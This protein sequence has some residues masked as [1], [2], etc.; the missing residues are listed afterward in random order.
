MV[1]R[2]MQRERERGVNEMGEDGGRDRGSQGLRQRVGKGEGGT[3][4]GVERAMGNVDSGIG[5]EAGQ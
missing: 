3:K 4:K 2:Q 5:K 1:K